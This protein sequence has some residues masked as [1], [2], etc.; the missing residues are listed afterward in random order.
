MSFSCGIFQGKKKLAGYDKN[1][2]IHAQLLGYGPNCQNDTEAPYRVSD[3]RDIISSACYADELEKAAQDCFR[4]L[5]VA[6]RENL[7][8]LKQ[9]HC[10]TCSCPDN[11]PDGW[12]VEEINR[13]L[14]IDLKTITRI[15]GGY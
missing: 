6:L 7:N 11:Q 13:V 15:S 14:A 8:S 4:R 5:Q 3:L 9:C 1:D 10:D 12:S 2:P